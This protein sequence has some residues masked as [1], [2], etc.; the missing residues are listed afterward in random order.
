MSIIYTI[1][2]EPTKMIIRSGVR[3]SRAVLHF[4]GGGISIYVKGKIG[5]RRDALVH[6]ALSLY[7]LNKVPLMMMRDVRA[8]PRG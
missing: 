7:T 8:I 4:E 2:I 1:S 3:E 5:S 6:M